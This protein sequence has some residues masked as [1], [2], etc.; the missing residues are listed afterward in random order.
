MSHLLALLPSPITDRAR[1]VFWLQV[2]SLIATGWVI[3]KTAFLPF[4]ARRLLSMTIGLALWFSLAALVMSGV[5]TFLLLLAMRRIE[6]A[7]A[8]NVTLRTSAAGIWFA[9][10]VMLLG[11]RSPFALT[12]A[13]ALVVSVTR[14]LYAQWHLAPKSVEDDAPEPPGIFTGEL[15]QGFLPRDF[16]PAFAA[17]AA[18]QAG[19]VSSNLEGSVLAG[20][21]YALAASL[22]TAYSIAA[23]V[24]TRDRNP[25]LPRSIL[26]VAVTLMLAVLIVA[27]GVRMYGSG[28]G[29]DDAYGT[30]TSSGRRARYE[31]PPPPPKVLPA[32]GK[33]EPP[34]I[35][36]ARLGPSVNVP[37][38]VP[39]VILWPETRQAP[40]LVEP[41]P[42]GTTLGSREASRPFV[43]P[44]AGSYWMFRSG[45]SRPP[46]N[47]IVERGTPTSTSFKTVD[48]WPLEME[49]H[50]RLDREI[51]LSCCSQ[52]RVEVLNAD[53]HLGTITVELAVIDRAGPAWR[54]GFA[55]I[56]SSPD[57]AQ[58]PVRPVAE[59]LA[60]DVPPNTPP[61]D[62]FDV[63]FHRDR[64]RGDRSARV[65]IERFVLVPK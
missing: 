40:L 49:A 61:F 12:A 5:I 6:R 38:G 13:L 52:I 18:L 43:I 37:G 10:A 19:Y 35:D 32:M 20:V 46:A 25:T 14:V 45:F 54:I 48:A 11:A 7:D 64:F 57:L 16:W 27:V 60:F 65:S 44:F 63:V 8:W 24:W 41:M 1:A 33:R 30:G 50:Q 21:F 22:L 53:Q 15:P 17:A 58:K 2:A 47:S 62:E 36:P 9:P 29:G 3:A 56:H 31:P 26:A 51:D 39:G 34:P 59:T 55:P 4:A 28:F 42:K 23:G